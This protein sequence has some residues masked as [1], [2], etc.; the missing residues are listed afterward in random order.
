MWPSNIFQLGQIKQ[1][2][3]M[4]LKKEREKKYSFL[5]CLKKK[6][7]HKE[8]LW[9]FTTVKKVKSEKKNSIRNLP[10]I[11]RA[12]VSIARETN[13]G[14]K[15]CSRQHLGGLCIQLDWTTRW[16]CNSRL[17]SEHPTLSSFWYL[18]GGEEESVKKEDEGGWGLKGTS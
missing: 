2:F 4:L 3:L 14:G 7:K 13:E 15:Q 11:R 5:L 1:V 6:K 16:V 12:V 17:S 9:L 10:T 18:E 8:G